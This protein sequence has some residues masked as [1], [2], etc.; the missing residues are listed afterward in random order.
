MARGRAA[1]YGDQLAAIAAQAARLFARHGYAATSV[2]QV[3]DACG[4]SKASLYHYVPTKQALL[5]VI[6][7]THVSRLQALVDEQTA[8]ARA[9]GLAPEP[10]LRNLITSLVHAY[11]GAQHAHRVL[12]EDVRFLEPA[13]RERVLDKERG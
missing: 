12:T 10:H 8:Q 2:Q 13:A 7:D 5:V 4:L 9:T 1:G 11:A 6:A 3:A